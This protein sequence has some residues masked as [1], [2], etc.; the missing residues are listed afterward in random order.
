MET[1]INEN[2]LDA[3]EVE[4]IHDL[5]EGI[6]DKSIPVASVAESKELKKVD[7]CLLKSPT[8]KLWL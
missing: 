7:D 2:K 3:T 5:Y 1:G 8:A 6:K 4:Q